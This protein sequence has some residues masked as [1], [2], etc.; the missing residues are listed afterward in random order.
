MERSSGYA[1]F[2][3][4]FRAEHDVPDYRRGAVVLEVIRSVSSISQNS[5]TVT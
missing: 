2:P 1:G 4:A 5:K 3:R